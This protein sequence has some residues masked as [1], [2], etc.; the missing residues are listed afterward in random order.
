MKRK[1]NMVR[2]FWKKTRKAG[3]AL[4]AIGLLAAAMAA[5]QG[6]STTNAAAA[7]AATGR[8]PTVTQTAEKLTAILPSGAEIE[9]VALSFYPDLNQ[10]WWRPN[11]TPLGEPPIDTSPFSISSSTAQKLE[12]VFRMGRK[13]AEPG[14]ESRITLPDGGGLLWTGRR[15]REGQSVSELLVVATSMP[16]ATG[17]MNLDLLVA[18]GPWESVATTDGLQPQGP[19]SAVKEAPNFSD[20]TTLVTAFF[21]TSRQARI[22][23]TDKDGITHTGSPTGIRKAGKDADQDFLFARTPP[24]RFKSFTLQTR[25]Y[26]LIHLKNISLTPGQHTDAQLT[27]AVVPA[28]K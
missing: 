16:A 28:G 2:M 24:A 13:A 4:A 15:S 25:P 7:A 21:A 5:G 14:Y 26:E 18:A 3:S 1:N 10:P 9:L 27:S 20:H 17:A 8:L 19:L 12:L 6:N 23:G 11:G 22:V